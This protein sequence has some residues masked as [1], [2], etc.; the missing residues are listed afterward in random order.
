MF[1]VCDCSA[2]DKQLDDSIE[3]GLPWNKVLIKYFDPLEETYCVV[4][5]IFLLFQGSCITSDQESVGVTSAQQPSF[6]L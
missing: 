6:R 5:K 4:F 1:L 3:C 2:H